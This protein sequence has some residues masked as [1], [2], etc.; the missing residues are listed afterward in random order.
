M[1]TAAL[2]LS[3]SVVI[4][5]SGLQLEVTVPVTDDTFNALWKLTFY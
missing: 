5:P 1:M 3:P 4:M 2:P